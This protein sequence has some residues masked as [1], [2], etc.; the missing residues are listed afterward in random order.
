[1]LWQQGLQSG[2]GLSSPARQANREGEPDATDPLL[3]AANRPLAAHLVHKLLQS[4]AS[5]A[6]ERHAMLNRTAKAY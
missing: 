1:L 6:A 3:D 2:A 4:L 5:A